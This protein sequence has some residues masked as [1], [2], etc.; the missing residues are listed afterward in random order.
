MPDEFSAA[1]CPANAPKEGALHNLD[2]ANEIPFQTFFI[3][4]SEFWKILIDTFKKINLC[5]RHA[6]RLQNMNSETY[7]NINNTTSTLWN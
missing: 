4:K 1:K 2:Y 7:L 3:W 6:R 5:K